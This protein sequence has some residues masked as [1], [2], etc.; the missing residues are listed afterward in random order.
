[1]IILAHFSLWPST[2][3][4]FRRWFELPP[5]L[6]EGS[7]SLVKSKHETRLSEYLRNKWRHLRS[8][9]TYV[10]LFFLCKIILI[11][12]LEQNG[13]LQDQPNM[14]CLAGIQLRWIFCSYQTL[15]WRTSLW[16]METWTCAVRLH[17]NEHFAQ[18]SLLRPGALQDL[19]LP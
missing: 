15:G 9:L 5:V 6:H 13:W 14:Q 1:M 18:W 16:L 2:I 12:L 8:A 3:Q 4:L 19:Q 17:T 10:K 11:L 7:N